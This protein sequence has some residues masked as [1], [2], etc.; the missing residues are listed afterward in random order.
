MTQPHQNP[1]QPQPPRDRPVVNPAR[2][3]GGGVA[4]AAV[5]ALVGLVG[6]LVCENILD[7]KLASPGALV[8]RSGSSVGYP[9]VA[10]VL[11][12]LATGLAHVLLLTAPRPRTFF[13]WIVGLCTLA[14]V[15]APFGLDIATNRQVATALVNL[16]IGVAIW[17]L[18]T[19]VMAAS[20][21]RPQSL[22]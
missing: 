1:V 4:T 17:S 21:S 14:G 16:L 3:W 19:T 10:F 5:A 7:I 13:S 20:V 22:R 11:A 15:A 6:R 2:L 18:V 9:F 12:L 8:G